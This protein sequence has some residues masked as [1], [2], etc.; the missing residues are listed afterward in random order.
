[1]FADAFPTS[2][3]VSWR[4]CKLS[5]TMVEPLGALG[6]IQMQTKLDI[7]DVLVYFSCL[8]VCNG[9][10]LLVQSPD[11]HPIES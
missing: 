9:T 11:L 10:A 5:T 7:L 4:L 2:A 8:S 3:R 6:T 1:M